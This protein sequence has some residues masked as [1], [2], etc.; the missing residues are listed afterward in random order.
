MCFSIAPVRMSVRLLTSPC[1]ERGFS[2][3][4]IFARHVVHFHSGRRGDLGRLSISSLLHLG[5]NLVSRMTGQIFCV[6]SLWTAVYL[7]RTLSAV[8]AWISMLNAICS[9][10][11]GNYMIPVKQVTSVIT[12]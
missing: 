8:G 6:L 9:T 4:P 7:C 5:T 1:R 3:P 12:W 10:Q 11:V 2:L